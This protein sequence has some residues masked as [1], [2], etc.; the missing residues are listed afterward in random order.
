VKLVDADQ[1]AEALT[2][3]RS[4]RRPAFLHSAYLSGGRLRSSVRKYSMSTAAGGARLECEATPG[5]ATLAAHPIAA[6]R[7]TMTLFY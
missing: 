1:S 4:A 3:L 2:E 6:L 5:K 7:R